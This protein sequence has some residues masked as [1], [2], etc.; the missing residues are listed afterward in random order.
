[1][2][3]TDGVENSSYGD[4]L[5]ESGWTQLVSHQWKHGRSCPETEER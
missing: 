1:M 4:S 3:L 2:S 5:H